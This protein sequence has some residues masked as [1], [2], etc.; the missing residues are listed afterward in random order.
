MMQN[1]FANLALAAAQEQQQRDAFARMQASGDFGRDHLGNVVNEQQR[2]N[3]NDRV[4]EFRRNRGPAAGIDL[5][6]AIQG[7]NYD[8]ANPTPYGGE[9]NQ[10]G[11]PI[12]GP[13]GG[14]LAG[15]WG[16]AKSRGVSA[17]QNLG[18][19][20]GRMDGRIGR[21]IDNT[22]GRYGATPVGRAV[23]R[24][25]GRPQAYAM[26]DAP[27]GPSGSWDSRGV[28]GMGDDDD[29]G[30]WADSGAVEGRPDF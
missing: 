15:M 3:W 30:G 2:R 27:V 29:Q 21:G 22:L 23:S 4:S 17:F 26:A 1:T 16:D 7:G 24:G 5:F 10:M 12:G 11:G 14:P 8:P 9:A 6:R 18:E 28:Y 13:I 25:L 20:I 19:R